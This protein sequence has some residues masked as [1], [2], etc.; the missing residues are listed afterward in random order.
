MKDGYIVWNL[1][2]Y[3]SGYEFYG[4]YKSREQAEKALREWIKEK[5][6]VDLKPDY[7]QQLLELEDKY[8]NNGTLDSHRITYFRREK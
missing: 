7:E 8:S 2:T 1:T 3:G 6:G 4:V 5:Y